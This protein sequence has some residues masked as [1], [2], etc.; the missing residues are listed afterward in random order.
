MIEMERNSLRH[1]SAAMSAEQKAA[2]VYSIE[3]I[4]PAGG[5][6]L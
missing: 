5:K 4:F 1:V 2:P 6:A 3:V